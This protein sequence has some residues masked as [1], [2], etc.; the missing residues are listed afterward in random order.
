MT[1][2][3]ERYIEYAFNNIGLNKIEIQVATENFKSKALPKKLGFKEEGTIRDAEWLNDKYV[4]HI[5]Y[6]LLKSEWNH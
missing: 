4:D 1:K 6:G 2:A 5:I 3:L